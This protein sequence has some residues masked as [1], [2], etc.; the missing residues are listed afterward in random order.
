MATAYSAIANG[1]ILRQPHIVKAIGGKATIAPRGHRVISSTYAA[2]LRDMLRGVL[3]DGGTASGA[4][5]PGYDLAGKTGTAQVVVNG[6]YSSSLY[7]ASFIGFVPASRPKLLVA[8]MVDEPNGAIYGGSV[9]A[10]AFQK[11]VGW[12]V[13]YLGISPK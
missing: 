7:V 11:I 12:A 8:V 9:A 1:G 5:I 4:A 2:E 3:A 10:P 13:P 6:K